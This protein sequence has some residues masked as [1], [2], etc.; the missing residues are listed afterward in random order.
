MD[1]NIYKVKHT[2]HPMC[3]MKRVKNRKNK[4]GKYYAHEF[5]NMQAINHANVIEAYESYTTLDKKHTYIIMQYCQA[6]SLLD[7]VDKQFKTGRFFHARDDIARIVIH[8]RLGLKAM[9]DRG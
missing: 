2:N 5:E 3:V 7:L 9:H 4:E 6:G 1:K 8:V